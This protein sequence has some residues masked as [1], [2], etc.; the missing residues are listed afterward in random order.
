MP[1]NLSP[2]CTMHLM[3][4]NTIGRESIGNVLVTLEPLR[5]AP[6]KDIYEGITLILHFIYNNKIIIIC[7]WVYRIKK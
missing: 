4:P 1:P 2:I 7:M 3:N 5:Y 6:F